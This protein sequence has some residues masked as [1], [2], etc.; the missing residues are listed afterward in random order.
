L[1][2]DQW[3]CNGVTS[4]LKTVESECDG[5]ISVLKI[6]HERYEPVR[7]TLASCQR[8]YDGV[9]SSL[10]TVESEGNKVTFTFNNV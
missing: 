8:R 1:A 10:K 3:R 9:I 7:F 4:V 2:N 5:V 6:D